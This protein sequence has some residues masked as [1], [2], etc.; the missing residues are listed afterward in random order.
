VPTSWQDYPSLAT[1]ITAAQ[2]NRMEAGI[3]AALVAP[4]SV[5]N[6]DVAAGAAIAYSKLA[7]TGA[8]LN[9]DIAAAAAIAISKLADPGAGKVIGSLGAGAVA[10][11]PSIGTIFDITL[12]GTQATIDS[13]TVLGGALPTTYRHLVVKMQA[14]GDAAATGTGMICQFNGDT[15]AANYQYQRLLGVAT[16]VTATEGFGSLAG[17]YLGAITASTAPA[18][19]ATSKHVDLVNYGGS[20]FNKQTIVHGA[21]TEGTTSGSNSA[22][23]YIANWR[24]V[25]AITRIVFLPTT[26]NFITGTRLTLYGLN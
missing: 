16:T 4:L 6:A 23:L 12:G 13:N 18:G 5:A 26:G 21:D 7:L 2:L 10:V 11:T 1:A 24:N 15:T 17:C 25:A 8:I 9:A 22:E 3:A 14:R 20:T 19:L